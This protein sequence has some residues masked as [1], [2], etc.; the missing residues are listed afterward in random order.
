MDNSKVDVEKVER[1]A[2]DHRAEL[3]TG[4]V[5]GLGALVLGA[6]VIKATGAMACGVGLAYLAKEAV[7]ERK[8]KSGI[9]IKLV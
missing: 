6:G 3:V 1:L 7:K 5:C 2:K 8:G 4:A 9:V